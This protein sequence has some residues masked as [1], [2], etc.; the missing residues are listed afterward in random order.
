MP[1][2]TL[3]LVFSNPVA[4]RDDDFDEWYDTV[5]VPEVV[6]TPG[7]VSARRYTVLDT[8]M[9][10]L[11]GAPAHRYLVVYEMDDDPDVVMAKVRAQVATGTMTM[12]DSLD[13]S[14]VAMSFWA[15]HG[16]L[17]RHES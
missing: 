1:N 6:A 4:G 5:H 12:H 8:E 13:L 9:S 11:A 10:R 14:G 2:H 17:V 7:M 15:P 3:Y 16:P